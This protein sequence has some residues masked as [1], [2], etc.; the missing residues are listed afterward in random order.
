MS[1]GGGGE[2][3]GRSGGL[4]MAGSKAGC[5]M[6]CGDTMLVCFQCCPVDDL[7]I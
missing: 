3:G 4:G 2:V 6:F 7:L 1:G 5:A